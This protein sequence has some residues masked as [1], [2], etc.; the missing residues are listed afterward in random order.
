MSDGFDIILDT[1][2]SAIAALEE[3][4]CDIRRGDVIEFIGVAITANEKARYVGGQTV[5]R[6]RMAGML[7]NLAMERLRQHADDEDD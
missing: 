2:K 7:M 4:I 6:H 1:Q 3:L 5:D